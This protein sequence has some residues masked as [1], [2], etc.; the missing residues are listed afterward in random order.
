MKMKKLCLAVALFMISLPAIAGAQPETLISGHM[1]SG[2]YGGPSLK[3]TSSTGEFGL[4]VGGQGAWVIN[5]TFAIGGGGWGLATRH[6]VTN[7]VSD[8]YQLEFGYGGV[9]LEYLHEP[10]RLIH[11]YFDLLIGAGGISFQRMG[12]F[13][14]GDGIENDALF[15]L[16]PGASICINI[17]RYIR[18]G[19]GASFRWLTG[20]NDETRIMYGIARSDLTGLSANMILRFGIY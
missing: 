12:G 13:G 2:G 14:P 16:E 11:Y 20:L 8:E 3:F 7:Q 6:I 19:F 5:K 1:E 9:L 10:D 4:L 15:I 18:I 17:M